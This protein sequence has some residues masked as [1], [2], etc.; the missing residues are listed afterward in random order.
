MIWGIITQPHNHTRT[1]K[2][3]TFHGLLKVIWRKWYRLNR[4]R[5]IPSS[6]WPHETCSQMP[7]LIWWMFSYKSPATEPTTWHHWPF[8]ISLW[9]IKIS[10]NRA[11]S[12]VPILIA[13]KL[14]EVIINKKRMLRLS[15][16]QRICSPH[17]EAMWPQTHTPRQ[18]C[19]VYPSR[20]IFF[21]L[22]LSN[23]NCFLSDQRKP[24]LSNPVRLLSAFSKS[25][26]VS[27]TYAPLTC[28]CLSLAWGVAWTAHS[29]S[30]LT[31]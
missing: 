10:E 29:L 25:R 8:T 30:S 21:F 4:G 16:T 27:P 1:K 2:H 20:L 23:T 7:V 14:P 5:D 19:T 26:C 12:Y 17:P 24:Q 3:I 31:A 15:P 11:P 9:N 13:T 18:Y 6:S 28:M 22:F